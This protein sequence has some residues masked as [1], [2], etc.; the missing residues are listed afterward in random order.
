[1]DEWTEY[2]DDM[3]R[4]RV[5]RKKELSMYQEEKHLE[6]DMDIINSKIYF[7]EGGESEEKS[8]FDRVC[9]TTTTD[10]PDVLHYDPETGN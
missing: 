1:M 5:C 6:R 10:S 3:G 2:T 8:I 9:T 7:K 4:T